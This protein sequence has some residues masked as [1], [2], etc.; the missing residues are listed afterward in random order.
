MIKLNEKQEIILKHIKEGKSQ[1]QISK[2]T[3]ISRDTIRKYVKDYESK[4]AEVN[5]GLGEIDKIDIIDDI[6]CA[7]KY[8]SSP[9]TKNALTEKV[10]E[11]L[12]EFLKENEQKRLRG[13]SK[14]QMKKID[15]YETLAEEGYQV[16]YAS[17]VRAVNIIERKKREAYIRPGILARRYCRI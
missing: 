3:G 1:R 2:E 13:L 9:R 17:V 10:L 12:S 5:K 14:Q 7:P 8:K 16:S 6:T 4:L 15:M 11:R